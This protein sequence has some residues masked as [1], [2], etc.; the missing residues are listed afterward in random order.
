[1]MVINM[2]IIIAVL[3]ATIRK[4]IREELT[5]SKERIAEAEVEEDIRSYHKEKWGHRKHLLIRLCNLIIQ[6]ILVTFPNS[7]PS[8]PPT[9]QQ[10][11]KNKNK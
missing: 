11:S 5:L 4:I 7:T 3:G 2:K 10:S 8:N 1:M 9:N 6:V